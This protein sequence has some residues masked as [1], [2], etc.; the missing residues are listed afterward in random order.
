MNVAR[1]IG[2]PLIGLSLALLPLSA[3]LNAWATE[4][5]A[6]V[7]S[8]SPDTPTAQFALAQDGESLL[9]PGSDPRLR[10]I[11]DGDLATASQVAVLVPGVDSRAEFFDQPL[12]LGD[13][14]ADGAGDVD[15]GIGG[16]GGANDTDADP[17]VSWWQ[18]IPGWARALRLTVAQDAPG[19]VDDVAV[20]AWL[21]YV[22]PAGWAGASPDAMR[23]GAANLVAFDRFLTTARPDAEV[24]WIC[25]SYGSLV[26]ASALVDADPDALVLIGSPGVG[27]ANASELATDATVWAGQSGADLIGL[28]QLTT[29]MGGSFGVLPAA[30]RFGALALPCDADAGHSDYFRPGSAQL[31]AM[32]S[33]VLGSVRGS[34]PLQTG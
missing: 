6:L 33:I 29:A 26:C 34:G 22:T 11:V 31:R 5:N 14:T 23:Q 15:G 1:W 16:Q 28:T 19:R 8:G 12:D 21:G 13:D 30:E 18:T 10:V 17:Q 20:V 24:T 25:H 4:R 27:V 7:R 3:Q 9:A 32:T 2:R